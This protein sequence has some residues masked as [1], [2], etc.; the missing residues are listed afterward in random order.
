[1]KNIILS[2]TILFSLNLKAQ[3]VTISNPLES[4]FKVGNALDFKFN[5]GNYLFKIGGMIQPYVGFQK[6]ST[7]DSKYLLNAKR[8]YFNISGKAAKEKILF[9]IQ[10]DFSLSSPLLDAW[11]AF[12]PYKNLKFTVGQVQT[13]AN[14]KEMSIMENQ[15]QFMDRSLVSE[16]YSSLGREFGL[17]I[18]SQFNF[19]KIGFV[20]QVAIT[21]GDGRNS[22]GASSIDYDFGGLKYAGRLNLYPL[23]YFSE[24]NNTQIADIKG[25]QKP[26][27]AIGVSASYNVGAT[28]S[29]GEGHGSFLLYNELGKNKLP[30]YRKLYYDLIFKYKGFSFLTEYVLATAKV[31]EGTYLDINALNEIKTTQISEMLSLGSGLNTQVGYVYNKKYGIDFRYS[32]VTPEFKTNT[33]SII[34]ERSEW[35]LGLTKYVDE[36]NLKYGAS[37]SQINSG[38]STKISGSFFVQIAF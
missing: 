21:S 10:T 16:Q 25:E 14:N 11:V 4:N 35:T 30:D 28:N 36:N 8:T 31:T 24:G 15:L 9:L 32:M 18:E 17:F 13:F 38:T 27:L 29:K 26:K 3:E 23:G 20:P 7:S 12:M 34:K 33:N 19:G 37:F 2:I 22:F 5:D 1:M 6:D